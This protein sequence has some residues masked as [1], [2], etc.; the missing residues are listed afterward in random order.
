MLSKCAQKWALSVVSSGL[1]FFWF[2]KLN[3]IAVRINVDVVHMFVNEYCC[4][5]GID[6]TN[7][8]KTTTWA[9]SLGW[10]VQMC[11]YLYW[12]EKKKP[13]YWTSVW[14]EMQLVFDYSTT[15][16]SMSNQVI[17]W[18]FTNSVYV[19]F[20]LLCAFHSIERNDTFFL[21]INSSHNRATHVR[22][23]TRLT[24]N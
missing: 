14:P 21:F 17:L 8:K 20:S 24:R 11:M 19:W 15:A 6:S 22:K 7:E 18:H 10:N 12:G 4:C 13:E 9:N 1:L 5:I 16:F 2:G 23:C 3:L